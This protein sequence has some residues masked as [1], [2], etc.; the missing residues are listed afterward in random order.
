MTRIDLAIAG[1]ELTRATGALNSAERALRR[2]LDPDADTLTVL[3]VMTA[4]AM[5]TLASEQCRHADTIAGQL[6][7]V[8]LGDLIEEVAQ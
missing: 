7:H 1:S 5:V 6:R 3:R 8:K 4:L 2:A